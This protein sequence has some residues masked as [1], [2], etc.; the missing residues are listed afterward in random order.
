M[1]RRQLPLATAALLALATMVQVWTVARAPLPAQ[2]A[3]DFVVAAQQAQRQ[4]LTA[5]LFAGPDQPLFPLTVAVVHRGLTALRCLAPDQWAR[6]A[7]IAAGVPLVLAV[8]PVVLLW[9]RVA[10]ISVA[11]AGGAL[12]C[13]MPEL[14]R[15]GADGLS[16]STHLLLAALALWTAVEYL[17]QS[18]SPGTAA[19]AVPRRPGLAWLAASGLAT[20]LALWTRAEA[21]VVAAALPCAVLAAA[22]R[23][24]PPIV[25]PLGLCCYA[26]AL[27]VPLAPYLVAGGATAPEAMIDRL[28]ARW[29]AVEE[30]PLNG[31]LGSPLALAAAATGPWHFDDGRPMQFGRKDYRFSSRFHGA[32]AAL[33]ELAIE[34][35]KAF[36]Y[37]GALLAAYGWWLARRRLVRPLDTYLRCVA[38]LLLLGTY[39]MAVRN[40]YLSSRHLALLVVLGVGWTAL[41]A[42]QAGRRL[43]ASLAPSAA[44]FRP[45]ARRAHFAALALV[46]TLL[47]PWTLTPRN[48]PRDAHRQAADWLRNRHLPA[49]A[50]VLDSCGYTALYTGRLTY[51][52]AKAKAAFAD[53]RLEVVV[54]DEA[55][56]L[57]DSPRGETLRYLLHRSA[58]PLARFLPS[59]GRRGPAVCVFQWT[60]PPLPRRRD[61]AHAR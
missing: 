22:L 51:R 60:S 27:A 33:R 8:V 44:A 17:A 12:F 24:T 19:G 55:E 25:A 20:G 6:S 5:F 54:V 9:R 14:A 48:A 13:L 57:A 61:Y 38:L 7:Q 36:S 18:P 3:V 2:D 40:G 43:A 26:V 59:S 37:I 46:G 41:G 29:R 15:L 10:G 50:A 23:R 34:L 53:P 28:L 30:L 47:L 16:D 32:G 49:D 39:A 45:R 42:M 11:L 21:L 52:Y 1:Q 31:T 58:R 35:P 4:P 56:L